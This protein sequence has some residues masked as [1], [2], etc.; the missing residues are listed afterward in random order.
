MHTPVIFNEQTC[1]GCNLCVEVCPMDILAPNVEKGK[2]PVVVYPDECWYD[3]ACWMRCAYKDKEAI[4]V[5]IPLPM[6]LS[7]LRGERP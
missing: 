3:G 5:D 6:K 4:K 2:P 7:I 1:N